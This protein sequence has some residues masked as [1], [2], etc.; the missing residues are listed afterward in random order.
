M[1]QRAQAA[2]RLKPQRGLDQPIDLVRRV[3]VRRATPLAGAEVIGRRQL[4]QGILD[5]NVAHEAADGS[6]PCITLR[7]GRTESGPVDRSL[8]LHVRLAMLSGEGRK[9]LQQV[10]R[11]QHRKAC[12]TAQGEIGPYGVEHHSASGQG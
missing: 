5:L 4:M 9:A 11:V 3:D 12:G 10:L 1:G 6:E 8:R 7:H 2:L